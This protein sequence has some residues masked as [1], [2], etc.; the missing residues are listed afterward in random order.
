MLATGSR[1]E[2]VEE[3]SKAFAAKPD[4]RSSIPWSPL[5]LLTQ[6]G[7]ELELSSPASLTIMAMSCSAPFQ[8]TVLRTSNG[9]EFD[10]RGSPRAA[11]STV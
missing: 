9:P 4:A 2:K 5:Y 6:T 7:H 10:T 1:A 11:F 8:F 3:N